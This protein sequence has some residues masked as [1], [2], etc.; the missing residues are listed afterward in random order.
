MSDLLNDL[1]QKSTTAE[2]QSV[3]FIITVRFIA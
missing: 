1:K 2:D 3:D